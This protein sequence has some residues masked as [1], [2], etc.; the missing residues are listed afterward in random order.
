M[1]PVALAIEARNFSIIDLLV[2]LGVI[3]P[4]GWDQVRLVAW[5][6]D[7]EILQK[8]L[9]AAD[10]A[11]RLDDPKKSFAIHF[12]DL[13]YSV[14]AIHSTQRKL[15]HENNYPECCVRTVAVLCLYASQQGINVCNWIDTI[16][17]SVVIWG[18]VD[19]LNLFLEQ[20]SHIEGPKET[21]R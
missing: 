13:I 10:L 8:I 11:N 14:I 3:I 12:M 1:T 16:L 4:N 15:E 6:C 7:Y 20:E 9:P 21:W 19:L 17:E 18:C 5:Q 2:Q